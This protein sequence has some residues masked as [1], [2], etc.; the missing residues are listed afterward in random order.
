[1]VYYSIFSL[2]FGDQRV[3]YF[4]LYFLLYVNLYRIRYVII[5]KE[6]YRSKGLTYKYLYK[7]LNLNKVY[8]KLLFRREKCNMLNKFNITTRL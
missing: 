3:H 1:M 5:F 6:M 8:F 7:Y 4:F 2:H